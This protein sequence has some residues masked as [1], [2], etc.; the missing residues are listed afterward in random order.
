MQALEVIKKLREVMP[1]KRTKM[2]LRIHFNTEGEKLF[3]RTVCGIPVLI[4]V[5]AYCRRAQ[6]SAQIEQRRSGHLANKRGGGG[7]CYG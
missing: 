7:P 4:I 3:N 6:H 2:L 5:V 1:I